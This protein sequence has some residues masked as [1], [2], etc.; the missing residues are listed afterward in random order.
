MIIFLILAMMTALILGI[1]LSMAWMV[2]EKE[3]KKKT[4]KK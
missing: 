1:F 2:E 4:H 3:K